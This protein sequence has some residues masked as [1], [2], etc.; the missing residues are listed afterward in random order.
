MPY[1]IHFFHQFFGRGDVY[2]PR[3]VHSRFSGVIAVIIVSTIA[4][5]L[6]EFAFVYFE[7]MPNS[8]AVF[9]ARL[10]GLFFNTLIVF[11]WPEIDSL[12]KKLPLPESKKN[13][14][15]LLVVKIL[16]N[17]SIYSLSGF[18]TPTKFLIKLSV[19]IVLSFSLADFIKNN[20]QPRIFKFI[21]MV[22]TQKKLTRVP[23]YSIEELP[24]LKTEA[25][26]TYSEPPGVSGVRNIR[27]L[28][29][30]KNK[31][32]KNISA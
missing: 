1:T 24:Q 27:F 26:V 17:T 23:D 18:G 7:L 20:F 25:R 4:F 9:F 29:K 5:A 3:S 6:V 16:V 31:M 2:S 28:K 11:F 30:L 19:A 12:V 21:V 14:F 32:Q 8:A 15:S 22:F 13:E 10:W